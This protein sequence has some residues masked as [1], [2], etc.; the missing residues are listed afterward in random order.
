MPTHTYICDA[1]FCL[2]FSSIFTEFCFIIQ[3]CAFHSTALNE[4]I[5]D[6]TQK[7]TEWPCITHQN[8][9]TDRAE[10]ISNRQKAHQL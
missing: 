6:N 3:L 9:Y 7:S 1:V 5:D 10:A 8:L 2:L 4:R